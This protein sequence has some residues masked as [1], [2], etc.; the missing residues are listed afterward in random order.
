MNYMENFYETVLQAFGKILRDENNKENFDKAAQWIAE[1][2]S[3]DELIYIVGSGGHSTMIAEECMCRAG[4]LVNLNPM[5]G[6]TSLYNGGTLSRLLQRS[7]S[8]AAGVLDQYYV[9]P[10]GVLIINNA[11]G[12]NALTIELAI[13]AGR[14]GIKTIGLSS[15]DH[16]NNTP[17]DQIGRHE[18]KKNLVEVVDILLDS[19]MPY[20]DAVVEMEGVD[21]KVGPVS[22]LCSIFTMQLLMVRAVEKLVELGVSP[23]IWRSINIPGGD[24]Y[25]SDFTKNFGTRVRHLR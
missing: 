16:F 9:Q 19:H 21:Q 18:S 25:N 2:I 5:L 11:Y 23:Q 4:M 22:T 1:A 15:S 20:G 12:I 6:C 14:R 7:A 13:E 17:P 8:Y 10:G 3:R 24:E